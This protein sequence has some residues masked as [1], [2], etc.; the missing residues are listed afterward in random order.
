MLKHVTKEFEAVVP[1][2]ALKCPLC[3][4]WGKKEVVECRYPRTFV[5]RCLACEGY[6]KATKRGIVDGRQSGAEDEE[7]DSGAGEQAG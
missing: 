6:F 2:N 7:A 5:V 1:P 3:A 4:G